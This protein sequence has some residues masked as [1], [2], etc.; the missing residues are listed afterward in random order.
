RRKNVCTAS[1]RRTRHV[2]VADAY[3][4]GFHPRHQVRFFRPGV[5]RLSPWRVADAAVHGMD[6]AGHGRGQTV[7][8][9]RPE[10]VEIP[11]TL[12]EHNTRWIA[13][14]QGLQ[15]SLVRDEQGMPVVHVLCQ[16]ASHYYEVMTRSKRAPVL[17]GEET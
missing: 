8:A 5:K 10:Q 9:V 17:I 15:G 11:A 6:L 1:L 4:V 14:R 3:S 7:E 2:V 16:A 12:I 13:V